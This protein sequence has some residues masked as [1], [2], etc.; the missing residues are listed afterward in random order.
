[1]AISLINSTGA[2]LRLPTK[3]AREFFSCPKGVNKVICLPCSEKVEAQGQAAVSKIYEIRDIKRK[4][5]MK[6]TLVIR[7]GGLGDL[8]M[9]SSGL[10]ELI[11]RGESLTLATI[12]E[13]MAFMKMLDLGPVISVEDIGRYE[14]ERVRD[15]RFAVEPKEM[16]SICKSDWTTYTTEDR[17]DAFDKLLGIFPARKHFAIP[18]MP[19]Y[20]SVALVNKLKPFHDGFILVNASM[21]ASARAIPLNYIVPLCKKLLKLTDKGVVLVGASQNWNHEIVKNIDIPGVVNL[22]DKTET[23]EMISLCALAGLVITPD[24]GTLHIAAALGKKTIALFGNINPRTRMSYYTTVRALYPQ[25]ELHCIPCWDLH[26]CLSKPGEQSKCMKLLT[27]AR[28]VNAA[29]E[30]VGGY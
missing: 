27:P 28:V 25:G 17:S 26:P 5:K 7:M 15:L 12:P 16:G 30:M 22:I 1:M 29:K 6:G 14:F 8:L 10:R 11:R 24:T 23:A 9:L 19:S 18:A 3:A 2:E 20:P 13:N 4:K 21:G